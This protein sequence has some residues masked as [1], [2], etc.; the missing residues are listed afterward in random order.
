MCSTT[1][2][3]RP[4]ASRPV[5]RMLPERTTNN[6]AACLPRSKTR[7]PSPKR[8][9]SANRRAA[10]TSSGVSVGN[11]CP[12]RDSRVGERNGV[13]VVI[14]ESLHIPQRRVFP[15]AGDALGGLGEEAARVAVLHAREGKRQR[16][17]GVV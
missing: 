16:K 14:A 5:M 8:R 15:Y 7:S 13:A 3:S 2:R 9:G 17:G 10:F 11:I 4:C 1:G 12:R 6:P